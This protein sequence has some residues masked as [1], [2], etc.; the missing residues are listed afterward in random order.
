MVETRSLVITSCSVS[1]KQQNCPEWCRNWP[2]VYS[3]QHFP[4]RIIKRLSAC[5]QVPH[6][7]GNSIGELPQSETD[8]AVTKVKVL[9]RIRNRTK[10]PGPSPCMPSTKVSLHPIHY[11]R[12][13]VPI[14]ERRV[15]DRIVQRSVGRSYAEDRMQPVT[16]AMSELHIQSAP[17]LN[18]GSLPRS[19][20]D[21]NSRCEAEA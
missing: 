6:R 14:K 10:N 21:S 3:T 2:S 12:L 18:T 11:F 9:A 19:T 4:G 7:D 1:P 8:E 15:F 5:T 17:V 16:N 13:H 20:D